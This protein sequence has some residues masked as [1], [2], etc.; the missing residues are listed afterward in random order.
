VRVQLEQPEVQD[1][2]DKVILVVMVLHKYQIFGLLVVG[3]V[4]VQLVIMLFQQQ[5]QE[6]VVMV[7]HLQSQVL[8]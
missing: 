3:V 7:Q 8:P 6:M 1:H 4:L 5:E 2:R